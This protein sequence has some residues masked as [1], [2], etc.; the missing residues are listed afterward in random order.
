MKGTKEESMTFIQERGTGMRKGEASQERKPFVFL[1]GNLALDLVNTEVMVR[2]KRRDLLVTPQDVIQWW[3]MTQQVYPHLIQQVDTHGQWSQER[4]EEVWHLRTTLRHLFEPLTTQHQ[5]QKNAVQELNRLLR[6]G[7]YCVEVEPDG[8]IFSRYRA[9]QDEGDSVLLPIAF[10]AM[11]LLTAYDLKRL[12]A[13]QNERCT[14]LFYD[15]T[16]SATR[17]WCSVG[18]TN[19]A[20]SIQNYKGTKEKQMS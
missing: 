10:A 20:R 6:A 19:R 1:S 5:I 18:C 4:F 7:Y 2:G 13:C 15:S 12:H 8:T 17:Q 11:D 16:K 9:R 3:E 14:L